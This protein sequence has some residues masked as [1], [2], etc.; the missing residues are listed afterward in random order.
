MFVIL[1]GGLEVAQGAEPI[2]VPPSSFT[3]GDAAQPDAPPRSVRLSAFRLDAGEVTV[4]AFEAFVSSA[5]HQD[6]AVW[7]A[8]WPWHQAHPGGAGPAARAAG[9]D[10]QHPVV[11]VTWH[12]AD[13]YC[14]WSGGRLPTEAEWERVACDGAGPYA[15]GDSEDAPAAWYAGSKYGLV[16]TVMTQPAGQADPATV[17]ALGAQHMAGNVWEWTADWYSRD[18]YAAGDAT[19]PTGPASGTWR[20][21]R[22]GSYMNL[23]SYCRCTHREPARPERVAFTVGFR[24][25]YPSR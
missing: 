2:D 11:A 21:L 7:G 3:Q 24:C 8:G 19:D 23:P 16:D 17:G 13:A 1:W 22:G 4:R 14:R 12:E 5:G 25:A 9:R 10:D 20:V 18:S 15:W 6:P